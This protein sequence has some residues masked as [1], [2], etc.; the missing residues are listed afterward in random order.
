[1]I[2]IKFNKSDYKFL[3]TFFIVMTIWL[4]IKFWIDQRSL[5]QIIFDV[6]IIIFKTVAAIFLIRWLI[7]KFIVEK[8]RY[9]IFIIL[10][11][12]VLILTG[13]IDLLRDYL[14]SGYTWYTLPSIDYIIVHSFY[15]SSADLAMPFLIILIKKYFEEQ[16]QMAH[17][18][19]A[20]KDSE[21]KLLRAQYNPHFLY[22]NLN[23]IDALVDYSPREIIKEYIL[24]LASLYR[25]LIKY[26]DEEILLLSDEIK[27]IKNYFFL[28][29]TRF[30]NDY[31]FTIIENDSIEKKHVLNG[32]LLTVIENVVKH[33][34]KEVSTIKT[35][36]IIEK[37]KIIIMNNKSSLITKKDSL[38]TGLK[39]LKTRYE[40]LIEKSIE[41]NDNEKSFT[42]TLP[43]I[44]LID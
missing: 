27:L 42:I 43:L 26:K 13:F 32:A 23:T 8:A 7:E 24:N 2:S 30:G 5:G 29:E 38:G 16:T 4:V 10:G 21:L 40:L 15:Y 14:G 17:V 35:E 12:A 22:N 11:I 28:I 1:M 18:E 25:S 39:N 20:Q 19:R 6:P 33:N 41:I 3:S 44:N 9:I 31:I 34:V 37:E 36:I